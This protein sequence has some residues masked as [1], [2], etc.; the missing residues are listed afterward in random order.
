[1]VS[2]SEHSSVELKNNLGPLDTRFSN[3]SEIKSQEAVNRKSFPVGRKFTLV[4]CFCDCLP[5][6]KIT[7]RLVRL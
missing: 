5:L 2:C 4:E 7:E 3:R 1:M 6:D